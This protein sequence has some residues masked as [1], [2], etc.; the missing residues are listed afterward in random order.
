MSNGVNNLYIKNEDGM[1]EPSGK[2]QRANNTSP[3]QYIERGSTYGSM[4]PQAYPNSAGYTDAHYAGITS[5]SLSM[6]DGNM[7][8][9]SPVGA[10]PGR[11][12]MP[13]SA[14]SQYAYPDDRTMYSAR[15]SDA[16]AA[17]TYPAHATYGGTYQNG[18]PYP[19]GSSANMPTN[20]Y[21]NGSMAQPYGR[22]PAQ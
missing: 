3:Q 9:Q 18:S 12:S 14:M 8:G 11:T 4:N 20:Y 19:S 2:R 7:L 5:T 17:S 22:G 10:Y 13:F 15:A 6:S 1:D 21:N 16:G